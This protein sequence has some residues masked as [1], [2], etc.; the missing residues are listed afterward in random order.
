M[1]SMLI[2]VA[3]V[4]IAENTYRDQP[5]IAIGVLILGWWIVTSDMDR[6]RVFQSVDIE[7]DEEDE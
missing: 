4:I 2:V 3:A 5:L 7:D 1:L 6:E